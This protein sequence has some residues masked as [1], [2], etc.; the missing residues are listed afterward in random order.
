MSAFRES[1]VAVQVLDDGTVC[2]G[3][4]RPTGLLTQAVDLD[5]G[6]LIIDL[7][8]IAAPP[9][10]ELTDVRRALWWLTFVFGDE[11]ADGVRIATEADLDQSVRS[12]IARPSLFSNPV[13]RFA[14]GL[15]LYRWWPSSDRPGVAELTERGERWL[16]TEL[17]ILA[18]Y[19]EDAFGGK[20]VAEALL[21]DNVQFVIHTASQSSGTDHPL[22]A[23]RAVIES[24]AVD[25]FTYA[26]L[27]RLEDVLL[28]AAVSL[29]E[30][31]DEIAEH[32]NLA[33]TRVLGKSL[34][35]D[36][37]FLGD[38]NKD[39]SGLSAQSLRGRVVAN[40]TATVEWGR[41][42]PR[43]L[44]SQE[45]N[46][47]WEVRDEGDG[48]GT[49]E[50]NVPIGDRWDGAAAVYAAVYCSAAAY[51]DSIIELAPAASGATE[52]G[53][54]VAIRRP[55]ASDSVRFIVFTDDQLTDRNPLAA[56]PEE[57]ARIVGRVEQLRSA[58]HY[59]SDE[60]APF[61]R[62]PSDP[63]PVPEWL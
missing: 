63:W 4:T 49:I 19:A 43:V 3:A 57:R 27:S 11:V 48:H 51:P 41:V 32:A 18:W 23:V 14:V 1:P 16:A 33:L 26:K 12:P 56:T 30:L 60:I 53:G 17:G 45:N 54:I 50:I 2:L 42:R 6:T 58:W 37:V 35:S 47:R 55:I 25:D 36:F 10:A 62:E 5:G 24:V 61:E 15:W 20:D 7:N 13:L 28:G 46:V 38:G 39:P 9:F 44:G 52:L 59:E 21:R 22:A 34:G 29:A 8:D 31:E 40:G